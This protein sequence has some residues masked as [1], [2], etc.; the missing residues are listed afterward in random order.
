ITLPVGQGI[1]LPGLLTILPSS[2]STTTH[3]GVSIIS[4]DGA[5]LEPDPNG[6]IASVGPVILGHAE[7]GIEEPFTQGGG[8]GGTCS[9]SPTGRNTGGLQLL[10]VLGL[11]GWIAKRRSAAGRR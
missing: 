1:T 11:L 7:A 5:I 2:S 8:G 9:I 4:I 3:D 10:F 6:P